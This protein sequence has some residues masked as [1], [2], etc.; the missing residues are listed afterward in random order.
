MLIKKAKRTNLENHWSK[1]R[2]LRNDVTELIRA[3][4]RQYFDGIAEKL[5][6][7]SLSP[8][9]WLTTLKTFFTPTFNSNIPPLE[10]SG[11][12][13]TDEYEKASIFNNY[14]K[15]QTIL[16][17]TNAILPE[18]PPPSYNTQLS[19]VVLTPLEVLSV[20]KT[21]KTGKASGPNGLKN[22]ILKELSKEISS[23]FCSLFNQSLHIVFPPT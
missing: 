17:D 4:K 1:F 13:F 14:F 12:V 23:P 21:L 16:D 9:D 8:K 10:S 18:L 6:S 19:R 2:T 5:K 22:R 20:L 3:S 15:N 7:K 11:H